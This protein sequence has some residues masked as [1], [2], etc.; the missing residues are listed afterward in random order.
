MILPGEEEE[1]MV[2][3]RDT[4]QHLPLHILKCKKAANLAFQGTS[5]VHVSHKSRAVLPSQGAAVLSWCQPQPGAE[6]GLGS[7]QKTA[8]S[9][10]PESTQ[11]SLSLKWFHFTKRHHRDQRCVRMNSAASQHLARQGEGLAPVPPPRTS[12][13]FYPYSW[14]KKNLLAMFETSLSDAKHCANKSRNKLILCSLDFSQYNKCS[15]PASII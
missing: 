6:P 13:A 12:S 4:A 3:G 14:E 1:G 15:Q 11:K 2:Q 8:A 10:L 7:S 9:F 5:L